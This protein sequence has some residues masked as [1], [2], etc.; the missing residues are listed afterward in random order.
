[1]YNFFP[2]PQLIWWRTGWDRNG[3][4]FSLS[5]LKCCCTS[6]VGKLSIAQTTLHTSDKAFTV[7]LDTSRR[8]EERN[9]NILHTGTD[10]LPFEHGVP[11][12]SGWRS[13]MWITQLT[14]TE[15]I[16]VNGSDVVIIFYCK[17]MRD[18]LKVLLRDANAVLSR[19]KLLHLSIKP[20]RNQDN[21]IRKSVSTASSVEVQRDANTTVSYIW[22][23][24]YKPSIIPVAC[25][26]SFDLRGCWMSWCALVRVIYNSSKGYDQD[27]EGGSLC[28]K[29]NRVSRYVNHQHYLQD[30]P[31]LSTYLVCHLLPWI[32][33]QVQYQI[34]QS[35]LH[36][37]SSTTELP[38]APFLSL[39]R[40]QSPV[41]TRTKT[42]TMATEWK[43]GTTYGCL[44]NI[45]HDFQVRRREKSNIINS[46]TDQSF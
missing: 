21:L 28:S 37:H 10:R 4:T 38:P 17:T 32:H 26:Q 6:F 35:M 18:F 13:K 29:K 22:K 24:E 5:E 7:I 31:I 20:S 41:E 2:V 44:S 8:S 43:I 34:W 46:K 23:G 12:C 19:A 16:V 15:K 30:F 45:G 33:R 36:N 3:D 40:L 42:Q 9:S 39:H 11:S 25:S 1:M 27:N 14:P